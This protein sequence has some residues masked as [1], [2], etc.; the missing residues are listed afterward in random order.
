MKTTGSVSMVN[1]DCMDMFLCKNSFIIC[2][3]SFIFYFNK[4]FA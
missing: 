2:K 3:F 4:I 1:D